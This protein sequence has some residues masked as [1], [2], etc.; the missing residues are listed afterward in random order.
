MKEKSENTINKNQDRAI[1]NSLKSPSA[2]K[3]E[4]SFEDN[5]PEALLQRKLISFISETTQPIQRKISIKNLGRV[6]AEGDISSIRHIASCMPVTDV[7]RIVEIFREWIRTGT[8]EYATLKDVVKAIMATIADQPTTAP[9]AAPQRT[10]TTR[11]DIIPVRSTQ[12]PTSSTTTTTRTTGVAQRPVTQVPDP[13]VL[14]VAPERITSEHS[15]RLRMSPETET[16]IGF[17]IEAGGHYCFPIDIEERHLDPFVNQTLAVFVS[18]PR[19]TEANPNPAYVPV[20]E[21]IIDDIGHSRGVSGLMVQVE[22]RTVPLRFDDVNQDLGVLIR[23]AIGS[24]PYTRMLN[25][26]QQMSPITIG[27]YRSRLRQGCWVPTPLLLGAVLLRKAVVVGSSLNSSA[28]VQHATTSIEL[29]AFTR[30]ENAEQ[31]KLFFRAAGTTIREESRQQTLERIAQQILGAQTINATVG[32]RNDQ[33]TM[34]KSPIESLLAA[35][36]RLAV[37]TAPD[38]NRVSVASTGPYTYNLEAMDAVR[39][40]IRRDGRFPIM[41]GQGR[42]YRAVAEKLQ[43]PLLDTVSEELRV[44]VE[45]RS[46]ETGA[47]VHAVNCALAGDNSS[48]DTYTAA[49]R[50]M[51]HLRTPVSTRRGEAASPSIVLETQEVLTTTSPAPVIA[52]P[53][54]VYRAIAGPLSFVDLVQQHWQGIVWAMNQG[55]FSAEYMF[56]QD[57]LPQA[58]LIL[59]AGGLNATTV[60]YINHRLPD[61]IKKHN[62]ALGYVN[63]V[64]Q[65]L[66]FDKLGAN[67]SGLIPRS[68]SQ[69]LWALLRFFNLHN[70][71]PPAAGE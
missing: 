32:G 48:L 54:P 18:R 58:L 59:Q 21:M 47:L 29:N 49:A 33:S 45:H 70:V 68:Q 64:I 1:Q 11:T 41:Q 55:T 16:H 40:Q 57:H 61:F 26:P 28:Q 12:T 35:D 63:A 9:V 37:P 5:R 60:N 23:S 69:L 50:R 3:Q 36:S 53:V 14:P 43:P 62:P 67:S 15:S 44:L 52:N 19:P 17:E 56:F 66:I 8:H 38:S 7:G 24:F 46:S 39:D 65:E 27:N 13:I 25:S 10:T 20:L 2:E 42:G 22:F 31:R 6:A 30:L 34:A 4:I 51:D 71:R